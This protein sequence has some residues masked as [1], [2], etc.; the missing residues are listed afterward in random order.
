VKDAVVVF[1]CLDDGGRRASSPLR[2]APPAGS[3]GRGL[4]LVLRESTFKVLSSRHRWLAHGLLFNTFCLHNIAKS[5]ETGLR[6]RILLTRPA[7]GQT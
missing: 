2:R 4:F 5:K 3:G 7:W 1:A 6:L